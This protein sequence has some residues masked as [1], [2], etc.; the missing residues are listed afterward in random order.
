[1]AFEISGPG[2]SFGV[3]NGDP[4][5]HAPEKGDRRSLFNGPAQVIVQSARDVGEIK[6]TATAEGLRR[7]WL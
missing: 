6:L 4:N 3:G 7:E 5:S 1:M 2:K